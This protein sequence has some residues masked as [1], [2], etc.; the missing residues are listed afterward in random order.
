MRYNRFATAESE[1][2]FFHLLRKGNVDANW[3]LDQTMR[4]IIIDTLRKGEEGRAAEGDYLESPTFPVPSSL[5]SIPPLIV[6]R[7]SEG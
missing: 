3:T 6:H 2:A 5:T 1:R 7:R 4:A